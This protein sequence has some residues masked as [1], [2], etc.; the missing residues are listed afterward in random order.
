MIFWFKNFNI[1][2]IFSDKVSYPEIITV[3]TTN[4]EVKNRFLGRLGK[5]LSFHL[6]SDNFLA[7]EIQGDSL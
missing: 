1:A 6:N 5:P 3:S 7:V 2:K 4:E